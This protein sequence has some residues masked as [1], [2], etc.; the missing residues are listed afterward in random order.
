VCRGVILSRSVLHT[1]KEIQAWQGNRQ[2]TGKR[3]KGS[4]S[5][6]EIKGCFQNIFILRSKMGTFCIK[7]LLKKS[8]NLNTVETWENA[9]MS[10]VGKISKLLIRLINLGN[11]FIN[12]F[13]KRFLLTHA[14]LRLC[15]DAETVGLLDILINNFSYNNNNRMKKRKKKRKKAEKLTLIL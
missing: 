1:G 15:T 9:S 3:G 8:G 11:L 14:A 7:P 12:I 4:I 10:L 2:Q 6:Q 5:F 13:T